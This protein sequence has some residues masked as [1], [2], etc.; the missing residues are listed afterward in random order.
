MKT[1]LSI[2]VDFWSDAVSAYD[3]LERLLQLARKRSIPVTAV[4]NHQQLLPHVNESKARRLVNVDMHSD[5]GDPT[6]TY[7]LECG[8]WVSY[9]RWR[10]EGEYLWVRSL[11]ISEGNCN[12]YQRWNSGT[13]WKRTK[14]IRRSQRQPLTGYLRAAVGMGIC[15][16]P[17]FAS[18][19]VREATRMLIKQYEVPYTKGRKRERGNGRSLRPPFREA[20]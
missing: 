7:T 20:V 9:V 17:G 13:D 19:C 6:E 5:F 8:T 10:K 3:K 18:A 4:M 1:Y 12:S 2:D 16:S 14:T 15:L 11:S